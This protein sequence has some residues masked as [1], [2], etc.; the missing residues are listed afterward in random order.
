MVETILKIDSVKLF[1][2]L[3]KH[4]FLFAD[5]ILI[6]SFRYIK[7]NQIAYPVS[8]SGIE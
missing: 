3:D 1:C 2:I 6:K 4:L 8:D 5:Y 7:L